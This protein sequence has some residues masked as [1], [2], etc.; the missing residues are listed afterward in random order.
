V[1]ALEQRRRLDEA[2]HGGLLA[3][4]LPCVGGG[5]DLDAAGAGEALDRLSTPKVTSAWPSSLMSI[6][7]TDPIDTPPICTGLPLTT[8]DESMNRA[9]TL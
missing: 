4:R 1:L 8:W 9:V 2:G 5:R 6:D 7:S 3:S